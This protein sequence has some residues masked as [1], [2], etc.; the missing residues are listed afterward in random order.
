MKGGTHLFSDL[1]LLITRERGES[2]ELS[3]DEEW[4]GGL[5]LD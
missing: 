4:D 2:V 1:L 3:T 5:P